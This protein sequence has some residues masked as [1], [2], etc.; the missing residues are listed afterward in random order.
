[1]TFFSRFSEGKKKYIYYRIYKRCPFPK[2]T[3]VK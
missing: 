2:V 3:G 1:M